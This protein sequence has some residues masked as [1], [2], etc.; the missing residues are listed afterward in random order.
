MSYLVRIRSRVR[1]EA[2][3]EARAGARVRARASVKVREGFDVTP[4]VVLGL[5][6]G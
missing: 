5:G 2:R 4:H 1:V 6:L 3:I